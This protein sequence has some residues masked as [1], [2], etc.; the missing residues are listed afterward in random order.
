MKSNHPKKKN[1]H[2]KV[3]GDKKKD[4]GEQEEGV[5]TVVEEEGA[6]YTT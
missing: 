4:E 3:N 5:E 6:G 1:Q 2:S